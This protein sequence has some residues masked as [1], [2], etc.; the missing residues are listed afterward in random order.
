MLFLSP[1]YTWK[2]WWTERLSDLLKVTQPAVV[3]LGC[4]LRLPVSVHYT[5]PPPVSL[6][7]FTIITLPIPLV[8][9]IYWHTLA[10]AFIPVIY[11]SWYIYTIISQNAVLATPS[12]EWSS[13]CVKNCRVQFSCFL[14][15]V[16]KCIALSLTADLL[17][18]NLTVNN[19]DN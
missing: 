15:T 8:K 3:E 18:W 14:K 1:F 6:L 17:I 13:M 7:W 19:V 10:L 11:Q 12:S 4:E 16:Q 9:H 2:T 5:S